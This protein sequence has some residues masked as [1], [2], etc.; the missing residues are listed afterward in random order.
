MAVVSVCAFT[1]KNGSDYNV[2]VCWCVVE[3]VMGCDTFYGERQQER[4]H[5]DVICDQLRIPLS[6]KLR[7]VMHGY[8][9][10]CQVGAHSL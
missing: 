9:L 1:Q 5:T 6:A 4:A 3:T 10:R 7:R 2:C 8:R